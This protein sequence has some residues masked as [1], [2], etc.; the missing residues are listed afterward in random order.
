MIRA[1][2]EEYE[3]E[4]PSSKAEIWT[5]TEKEFENIRIR[6]VTF[7]NSFFRG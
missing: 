4:A 6:G 2:T 7:F 1:W 3:K 5:T